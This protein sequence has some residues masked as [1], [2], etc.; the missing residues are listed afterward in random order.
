MSIKDVAKRAGVAVSTVSRVLNNHA[1]VS[2]ETKT[3][4][5]KVIK[6][7]HYIPNNSAR[8]LKRSASKSIGVFVMGEH[9]PFFGEIIEVIEHE[10]SDKE[11]SVVVHFHHGG[12]TPIEAA[13]QFILEKKL[14][15]LI[16]LGGVIT[17]DDEKFLKSF[18]APVVFASTI[19]DADL[20]FNLFSS[21]SIDEESAVEELL[22]HL[23]GL[24]HKDIGII[25]AEKPETSAAGRRFDAYRKVL[26]RNS[27]V[28]QKKLMDF[29]DYSMESGYQA[30]NRI[31]KRSRN[32]SALF[33]INDLMAIG[34]M[35][36][37]IEH[38]LSVPDDISIVGFDGLDVGKYYNPSLTTI[39]QPN[40]SF[41]YESSKLLFDLIDS[42]NHR[43][44]VLDTEFLV[45][46][47]SNKAL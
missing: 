8:N 17:K 35:R 15:G 26:E 14:L 27:L 18:E 16:F 23:I 41:G 28:Y 24:G 22:E 9:N 21:V 29:G 40:R 1:D 36:S 44:T 19:I 33:V 42:V 7:M 43:H 37:V 12:L 6:E 25:T 47:S 2:A 38:G 11:L 10:F 13:A 46:E 31:L 32:F 20:D 4:V 5:Q 45:R 3:H 34:A 39:K 30:M